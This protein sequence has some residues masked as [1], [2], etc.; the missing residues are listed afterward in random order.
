MSSALVS[1]K[2]KELVI[3]TA[4]ARSETAA[5]GLYQTPISDK[6]RNVIFSKFN[7]DTKGIW[8]LASAL[9]AIV[10]G[11]FSIIFIPLAFASGETG[12]LSLPAGFVAI[13]VP[14]WTL[15][16]KKYKRTNRLNNSITETNVQALKKW[17]HDRYSII[18]TDNTLQTLAEH[19]DEEVK[20][21]G[22]LAYFND[23]NNVLYELHNDAYNRRYVLKVE[24][25]PQDAATS[26]IIRNMS[27]SETEVLLENLSYLS[28]DS[29][30]LVKTITS[31]VD[32][33]RNTGLTTEQQ[34]EVE[35]IL[36]EMKKTC[37]IRRQIFDINQ[38][39]EES[40]LVNATLKDLYA[41]AI[42]IM[43]EQVSA[44]EKELLIQN[45]YIHSRSDVA[46]LQVE[47]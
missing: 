44:L 22:R 16:S 45:D 39:Q 23:E 14:I 40:P 5:N 29:L 7:S 13:G 35:H 31:I 37:D 28:K 8:S 46:S 33:V 11:T 24:D 25:T 1:L 41:R 12:L 47:K 17:L 26:N 42:K 32:R 2:N 4:S 43:N 36:S 34:Y 15:T 18:V 9:S 19:V 30:N 21:S 3:V 20:Q 27:T 38:E 10:G 6:H